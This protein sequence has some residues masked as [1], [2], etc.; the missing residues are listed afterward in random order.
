[1]AEKEKITLVLGEG[2]KNKK[3][4]MEHSQALVLSN[5]ILQ[6]F[7]LVSVVPRG[8]LRKI[9]NRHHKKKA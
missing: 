7:S 9:L 4:Y 8:R 2:E 3:E 5:T 1:M 6:T